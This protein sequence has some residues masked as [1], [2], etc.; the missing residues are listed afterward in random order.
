MQ[1]IK[2][3]V[4]HTV[5]SID[6][7]GA[8]EE[9]GKGTTGWVILDCKTNKV[10]ETGIIRSL[11]YD[12]VCE[13]W[14]AHTLLIRRYTQKYGEKIA[15]S[16]ESYILYSNQ[17]KSHINSSMETSQLIGVMRHYCWTYSVPVFMR[18]AVMAKTRYSDEILVH[19]K[20]IRKSAKGIYT[21][22]KMQICEHQVD[23]YRHG[24]FFSKFEN[25]ESR[26]K[27]LGY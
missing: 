23:A 12:T 17:A 11:M 10:L 18:T 4:A 19:K 5:L 20:L 9:R 24:L 13:Y 21:I 22:N 14:H 1:K 8:F 3:P 2:I 26:W 7:S 25:E 16:I 6:P 15:V 27:K